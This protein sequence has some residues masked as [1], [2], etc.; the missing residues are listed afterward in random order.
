MVRGM[1]Q[2]REMTVKQLKNELKSR[3]LSQSGNKDEL[4][5][6]LENFEI[7]DAEIFNNG[8]I[9]KTKSKVQVGYDIIK[10]TPKVL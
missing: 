3:N 7:I 4:V 9:T 10:N 1:K 6:K 2:W 5:K 8:I